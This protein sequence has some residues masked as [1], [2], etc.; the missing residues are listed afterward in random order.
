M[1]KLIFYGLALDVSPVSNHSKLKEFYNLD[2]E[3]ADK[4]KSQSPKESF[5]DLSLAVMQ[6]RAKQILKQLNIL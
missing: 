3:I 1:N 6:V 5:H 4:L 2:K